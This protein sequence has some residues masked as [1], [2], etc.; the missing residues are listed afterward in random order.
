MD[1]FMYLLTCLE[2]RCEIKKIK[3]EPVILEVDDTI[4]TEV[5]F[6]GEIYRIMVQKETKRS[7]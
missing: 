3:G 4:I 7:R 6:N 5:V 2:K 1:L